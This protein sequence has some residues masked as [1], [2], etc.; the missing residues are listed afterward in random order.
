M[1]KIDFLDLKE[2]RTFTKEYDDYIEARKMVNKCKRGVRLM[3]IGIESDNPTELE[4][5]IL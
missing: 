3:V 2:K 1:I 4:Y 5:V